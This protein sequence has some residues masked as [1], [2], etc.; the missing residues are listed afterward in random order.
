MTGFVEKYKLTSE[1][2][3][4]FVLNICVMKSNQTQLLQ[5]CWTF[6]QSECCV[7]CVWNGTPVYCQH[8]HV[9]VI[10]L[11]LECVTST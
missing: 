5:L 8:H 1:K 11:L 3:A 9:S 10:I 4:H 7:F 2:S 6:I